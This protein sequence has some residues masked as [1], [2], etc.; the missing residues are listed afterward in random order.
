MICREFTDRLAGQGTKEGTSSEY[1]QSAGEICL[2]GHTS[3]N[4]LSSAV[5]NLEVPDI[6]NKSMHEVPNRAHDVYQ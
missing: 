2:P 3:V 4:P 1:Q 5:P 6:P